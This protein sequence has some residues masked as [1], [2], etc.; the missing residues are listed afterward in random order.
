MEKWPK[1]VFPEK[2]TEDDLSG[3]VFPIPGDYDEKPGLAVIN[4]KEMVVFTHHYHYEYPSHFSKEQLWRRCMSQIIHTV[5]YRT[6]DGGRTWECWGHMPFHGGY[7]ASPTVIDGVIYVQTHEFSNLEEDHPKTIDRIFCSEDKGHSW[8]ET[9]VDPAYLGA[10]ENT[11]MCLDRNFIRLK[12][13][14]VAGFVQVNDSGAGHTVRLTTTDHGRTWKQDSVA[15][16]GVYTDASSLTALTEAFFFRT[17][18]TG[19][20]MAISRVVWSQFTKEQRR[21]IPY[22]VGQDQ[23]APID[24]HT[25]MLLLESK[26]EGLT[27]DPVRGL[28]YLGMMYPSV[29]YL[30]D[31]DFVLTYT[32]RTN[33]T[34]S[35]YP[36]MGVQAIL[37]KEL[38]DGSFQFNFEQDIVVIDDRT[39]DYSENGCGYGTTYQLSDGSFITPYSYR[40][41]GPVLDKI[42]KERAFDDETFLSYYISS[43][44]KRDKGLDDEEHV[45][46]RYHAAPYDLRR[47]LIS[48][49]ATE[50]GE[51]LLKSQVLKWKLHL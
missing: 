30:N 51:T 44:Q 39:P 23:D 6:E 1:L 9:Q 33:T 14:S 47:H 20:L 4:D 31:R 18:K 43:K 46:D 2:L 17:P 8:Y 25:G 29:V 7:E 34:K 38:P 5:M 24:S 36:H 42:L 41:N 19:R 12:D 10:S 3:E 35:P 16:R 21:N 49:F 26:D 28:G 40:V 15:E 22:A 27:W 11:T 13:G 48:E 32:K 45:L 37:G 50:R